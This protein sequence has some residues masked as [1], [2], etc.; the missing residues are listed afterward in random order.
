M[1]RSSLALD[2]LRAFVILLVLSFHSVLAYLQFLPAAPYAFDSPPYQ[3]RAIPIVDSHRWLGFD[4]Y[5]A[6]QDVFLMSLFFFL[7]GLFVWPSL[8]RKGAANFLTGRLLRLGLPFAL[9]VAI[10]M[11]V[12]LYPTY[13]QT[14]SDPGLAAYWRHWLALPFWPCGPMWFLWLLLV[15]DFGA[16]ALHRFAP[17]LGSF[18]VRLS[19]AAETHP[20]RF[21]AGFVFVSI[22]AY[23]PLALLFTPSAW[24]Q[25][26][27]FAFQLSRPLHYALYFFAGVG[28]GAGGVERGL[29]A[30]DGPVARR[31][32]AWV[33]AALVLLCAWMGLT[34]LTME[35]ASASLGLQILADLSFVL[36]CF[37]SCFAVLAVA[38]RFAARRLPSLAGLSD[39][40]YGMYLVHYLFVVWL[41]FALL[42]IAFPA[43]IKAAVVF[44][45]TLFLS[46]WTVAALRRLPSAAQIIGAERANGAARGAV[47]S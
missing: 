5:C 40:A 23:V 41:Q 8:G 18:M 16:A 46:R 11:P 19:S 30:A 39:G 37:S 35:S 20:A 38:L 14:T 2:N 10:L 15:G 9:V 25:L 42:G 22:L 4:L 29:L 43:I 17:G 26:G 6:W 21:F 28:L 44:G 45:C 31:W 7:S 27:P 32:V 33:V 13:L 12:T 47:T 36:A 24:F 1:R 3:W 34:G